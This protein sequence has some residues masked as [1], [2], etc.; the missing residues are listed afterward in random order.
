MKLSHYSRTQ[1]LYLDTSGAWL[2]GRFHLECANTLKEL[3]IAEGRN[4]TMNVHS[5][6]IGKPFPISSKSVIRDNS[7]SGKQLRLL[8]IDTS[9]VR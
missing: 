1:L 6:T 7:D 2:K 4:A 3:G 5:A 8:I 9:E